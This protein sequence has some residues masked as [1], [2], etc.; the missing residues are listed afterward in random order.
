MQLLSEAGNARNQASQAE[1]SLG[2][3][4]REAERL[5]G[6]M[7]AARSELENLGAERGQASLQFE[8]VTETLSVS[9]SEIARAPREIEQTRADEDRDAPPRSTRLRAEQATL[10]GRRNSLEGLIREHSYSTDTV[11][12]LFRTNGHTSSTGGAGLSAVGTLA[13][14]LEV[15][16]R[17]RKRRRRISAR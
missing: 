16:R 13:D 14:F 1:E 11:R 17:V 6:E 7:D 10:T 9:N 2:A 12:K 15:E 8:S 3:L 5:A 4:E